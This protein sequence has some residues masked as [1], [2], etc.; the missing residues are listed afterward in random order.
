MK[1]IFLI[2]LLFLNLYADAV[3]EGLFQQLK[4]TPKD[5]KFKVVNEIKQHI[6]QLK[7]N[8]RLEAIKV[9]KEKKEEAQSKTPLEND[10][11]SNVKDETGEESMDNVS[12]EHEMSEST[13]EA[14]H[15]GMM[16][17][18]MHQDMS[19]MMNMNTME[20][21]SIMQNMPLMRDL[22]QQQREEMRTQMQGANLPL[23]TVPPRRGN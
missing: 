19:S 1:I 16:N 4:S 14:M 11:L 7:Q 22:T 3:L 12:H 6:I 2:F 10:V 13:H 8:E 17:D 9:L 15:E 21:L 20:N 5:D 18:S 23:T